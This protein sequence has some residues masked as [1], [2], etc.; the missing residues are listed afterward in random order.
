MADPKG[1]LVIV[2]E[3]F[4]WTKLFEEKSQSLRISSIEDD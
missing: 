3:G 4:P 1:Y 2:L